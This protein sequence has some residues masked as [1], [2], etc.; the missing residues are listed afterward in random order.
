[1]IKRLIRFN[2]GAKLQWYFIRKKGIELK[3]GVLPIKRR[4][5]S[6]KYICDS[7]FTLARGFVLEYV[8]YQAVSFQILIVFCL[9]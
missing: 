9:L 5:W 6:M 4:V 8:L 7:G 3:R 1:M 2:E